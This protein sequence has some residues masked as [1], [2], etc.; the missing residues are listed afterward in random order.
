MPLPP[1]DPRNRDKSKDP[2]PQPSGSIRGVGYKLLPN[3]RT[4]R[5]DII[6]QSVHPFPVGTRMGDRAQVSTTVVEASQR[7]PRFAQGHNLK[8]HD[9]Y[10]IGLW[11]ARKI[12]SLSES[13]HSLYDGIPTAEEYYDLAFSEDPRVINA[14]Q[15]LN[16]SKPFNPSDFDIGKS[17]SQLDVQEQKAVQ[18]LI[19][20][21][22]EK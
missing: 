3:A 6:N 4:F 19:M 17:F 7:W 14:W 13:D 5:G 21:L 11:Q 1:N 10:L 15:E 22:L 8:N 18:V 20:T 12:P 9:Q 16:D 2:K